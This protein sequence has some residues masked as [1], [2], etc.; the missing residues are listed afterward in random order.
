MSDQ[1]EELAR[2][3]ALLE[4]AT[5]ELDYLKRCDARLFAQPLTR[6]RIETLPD[7][8]D[9]A[10]RV[11]AFVARFGRLQDTLGDKLLPAFL[12][13]MAETPG[14]MLENLDRAEKLGL[15]LSADAW[16]ALRKLRNRM[17]HEYVADP[18]ELLDALIAAH[19]H[20]DSLAASYRNLRSRLIK[21]FPQIDGLQ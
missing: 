8:D 18:N 11:D 17:I 6:E 14:T 16:I 13:A 10:E 7:D 12:R 20:V 21:R 2:L 9:L 4:V 5:R 15:I 3:R 19:E 1:T